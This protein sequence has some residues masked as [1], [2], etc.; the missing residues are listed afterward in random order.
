MDRRRFMAALFAL[1]F[2]G[3]ALE[4]LAAAAPT[5]VHRFVGFDAARF[6]SAVTVSAESIGPESF[7]A[8]LMRDAAE[9]IRRQIEDS[10]INGDEA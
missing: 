3:K 5:A 10:F 6:R 8:F 7:E 2:A 4:T 9:A 1:P